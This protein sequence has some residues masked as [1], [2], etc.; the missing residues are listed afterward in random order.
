MVAT[1]TGQNNL[2]D[3]E[4]RRVLSFVSQVIQV[5]EQAFQDVLTLMLD[6]QYLDQ[7]ELSAG[8]LI[9]LRKRV[10]LLTARSYYRDAAEICSRLKHLRENFDQFIRPSVQGLRGFDDWRGVFGLIE[11]R[12]GRIIMLIEHTARE[13][14]HLLDE[15]DSGSLSTVRTKAAHSADELRGLLAELHDLNG[16]ILGLSGRS[17]YLELTRDRNELRREVN[18]MIDARDQSVT[19]GPRVSVGNGNTF[20]RDFVVAGSIQESFNRAQDVSDGELR[21]KLEELCNHV[22]KMTSDL[23]QETAAQVAQ[24]LST[25]VA[26]ASKEKPRRKWYE[27]SGDGL[28]EAAKACAGMASPVIKSVKEILAFLA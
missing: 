25:F 16:R 28:I 2:A 15:A 18:L 20:Q 12:E 10:D 4:V 24:D 13:I 22:E 19:H 9:E 8:R 14:G 27:L 3:A 6:I 26:E 21:K 7:S 1:T 11:E 23:P 5:I 17:G